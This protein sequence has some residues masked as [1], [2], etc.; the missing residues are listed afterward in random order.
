MVIAVHAIAAGVVLALGP[1]VLLRRSRDRAHKVLGRTWV[2]AI[3]A[4]CV[5]SFWIR[6]DGFSWLHALSVWTLVSVGLGLAAIRRRRVRVHRANMLGCYLGSV[7][8]FVFAVAVPER[9]IPTLLREQPVIVGVTSAAILVTV[10]VWARAVT[11]ARP[12]RTTVP[13]QDTSARVPVATS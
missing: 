10:A 9:L 2:V 5:S 8:A 11:A 1:V 4:V 12:A 13:A 7:A 6:E 3:G